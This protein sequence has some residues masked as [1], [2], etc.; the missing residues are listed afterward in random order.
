MGSPL[1]YAQLIQRGAM[2]KLIDLQIRWP[3]M[4]P[5]LDFGNDYAL[6][7]Q[8]AMRAERATAVVADRFATPDNHQRILAGELLGRR[9]WG[10][11][12]LV[13]NMVHN[14]QWNLDAGKVKI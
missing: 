5:V 3:T 4:H 14:Q 7:S 2:E 13:I 11:D 12:T 1:T 8:E 10:G 9:K 6:T